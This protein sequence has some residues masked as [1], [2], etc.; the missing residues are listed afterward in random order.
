MFSSCVST[1]QGFCF[2]KPWRERIFRC[3]RW[4]SVQPEY[5]WSYTRRTPKVI[6]VNLELATPGLAATGALPGHHQLPS[7]SFAGKGDLRGGSP[8][9][10]EHVGRHVVTCAPDMVTPED[11][12]AVGKQDP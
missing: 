8:S 1:D 5:L 6:P 3:F 11:G 7:S 9:G 10:Q 12:L 2:R 4:F